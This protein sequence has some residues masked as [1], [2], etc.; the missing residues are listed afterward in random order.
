MAIYAHMVGRYR[1]KWRSA[2][3]YYGGNDCGATATSRLRFFQ[4]NLAPEKSAALCYKGT[5]VIGRTCG[6]N[7][8][9][10]GGDSHP[11]TMVFTTVAR[12][13]LPQYGG[14]SW[15]KGGDDREK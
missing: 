9:R 15:R 7:A 6:R 3:I 13:V 10:K 8:I 11:S 1:E 5:V 4:L 2:P 14:L 12:L